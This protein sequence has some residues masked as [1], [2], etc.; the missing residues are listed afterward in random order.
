MN[1][2]RTYSKPFKSDKPKKSS[3]IWSTNAFYVSNR[4]RVLR[5][6][7]TFFKGLWRSKNF[8]SVIKKE[9]DSEVVE[10]K[11]TRWSMLGLFRLMSNPQKCTIAI[12][13]QWC[14]L[15]NYAWIIY[16]LHGYIDAESEF[17]RTNSIFVLALSA[18]ILWPSMVL[19]I[20]NSLNR[21]NF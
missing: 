16:I 14:A 8:F 15:I 11:I 20:Y 2:H 4:L 18:S 6:V 7:E 21:E 1:V 19:K 12:E 13:D 9:K 3:S 17:F 10:G 5:G